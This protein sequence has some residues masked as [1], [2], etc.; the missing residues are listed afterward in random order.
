MRLTAYLALTL[1]L[2]AAGCRA[3]QTA[4]QPQRFVSPPPSADYK[5]IWS[6]EFDGPALD[7]AKWSDRHLG[8]RRDAINVE[9]AVTLDG[10]GHLRITTSRVSKPDGRDE[11]HT[12]MIS[13][14]GHFEATY[15]Y[16][17]VRLKV[18]REIGHWSA[19]WLQTP[20][21]GQDIGNPARAGAE[22]DVLEYLANGDYRDKALHTIHWD[23][24]GKQH[25]SAHC[26]AVVPDIRDGFH[27]VG[28]EW[29]PDEYVFYVDGSE[30]WRTTQGVSRRSEYIILSLEV[31]KWADDIAQAQLPDA[32]IVDYVRVYQ[33]ERNRQ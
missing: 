16:F 26:K 15:G 27:T 19:F 32:L 28:L 8:P 4:V 24:Y 17:E 29:T 21:M 23:G 2:L 14:Q 30:T 9:D 20:T 33:R 12:G 7:P 3:P 22:I 1:G 6:D 5:L 31:G 10:Q 11:Y 13:T 18:Q 25:E